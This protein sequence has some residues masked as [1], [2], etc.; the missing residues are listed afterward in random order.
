MTK[1]EYNNNRPKIKC[2]YCNREITKANY[3]RHIRACLD[4]NSKLNKKVSPE[5]YHVDHNDLFCKFCNKQLCSKNALAQHEI[6][7]RKNENRIESANRDYKMQYRSFSQE[8][9][10]KMKWNNGLTKDTDIRVFRLSEKLSVPHPF[11]EVYKEHNLQEIQKWLKY[12]ERIGFNLD[13]DVGINYRDACKTIL[14]GKF[15]DAY[16]VHHINLNHF[17]NVTKNLLVF[18]DETNHKR[19]HNSKYGWL[20][21]DEVLHVFYCSIRT[22]N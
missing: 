6:R 8:T 4:P 1:E 9:K 11:Q 12:V 5:N 15:N 19:Y 10:D 17:D 21:Y 22:P 13:A 2:P 7:C 18:I 16:I 20:M 3:E 14:K